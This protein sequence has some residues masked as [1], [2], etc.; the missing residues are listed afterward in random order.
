M[1]K[2][3]D[4]GITDTRFKSWLYLPTFVIL[5]K[6]LKLS[7]FQFLHMSNGDQMSAYLGGS[8]LI[9]NGKTHSK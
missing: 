9:L 7:V 8:M 5:N 2:Y 6:L 4:S 3:L 1:V